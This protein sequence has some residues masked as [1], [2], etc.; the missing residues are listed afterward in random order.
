MK[1]GQKNDKFI[2]GEGVITDCSH[3]LLDNEVR[4]NQNEQA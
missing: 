2:V 3:G 1:Y 4:M